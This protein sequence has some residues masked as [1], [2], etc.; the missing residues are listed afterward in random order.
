MIKALIPKSQYK[1]VVRDTAPDISVEERQDVFAVTGKYKFKTASVR[2]LQVQTVFDLVH[3][4]YSFVT[5]ISEG[6]NYG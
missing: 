6:A 2:T 1:L 4:M 5:P 3:R